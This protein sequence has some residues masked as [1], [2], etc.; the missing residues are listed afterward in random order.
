MPGSA[1]AAY[2]FTSRV[3]APGT[4]GRSLQ[5]RCDALDQGRLFHRLAVADDL[6]LEGAGDVTDEADLLHGAAGGDQRRRDGEKRIAGAHRVDHVA[7]EGRDGV[8]RTATLVGDAAVATVR[9]DDLAAGDALVDDRLRHLA[10][11]RDAVAGGEPRLRRVDAHVVR[12]RI[13]RDQVVAHVGAV[14]LG[15]YGQER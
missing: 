1:T 4:I 11:R 13:T 14:A 6:D 8:R 10:D 15:V 9:D 7:R 2:C 5:Q 12:L 3:G